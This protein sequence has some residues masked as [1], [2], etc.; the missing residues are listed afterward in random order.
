MTEPEITEP[1]VRPERKRGF[2][3]RHWKGLTLSTIVL[4]PIA[5]LVV[6]ATATLAYTY[7]SGERT[8][9]NQKL[10]QKGW[11]CKTWEGELTIS[12]VPGVAPQLFQYSVRSDSVAHAIEA[13]S[14]RMVTLNWSAARPDRGAGEVTLYRASD[15][16]LDR[17]MAVAP[18]TLGRQQV[19]LAALPAGHWLVQVQWRAGGREYYVEHAVTAR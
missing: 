13:L 1:A 11:V 14:G 9:Y 16:R 7:S 4:L 2:A 18:D 17:T 8:G 5:V 6:W 10:S 19:S 15:D 3:R 12:S